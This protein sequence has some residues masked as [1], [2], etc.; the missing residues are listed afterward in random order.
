MRNEIDDIEKTLISDTLETAA[1]HGLHLTKELSFNEMGLDFRVA[2]AMEQNG[3]RW[4]L[5]IP[6]R[7]DIFSQIERE[8]KILEFVKSRV[9]VQ[10]PDWQI[11][12]PELVA[13]PMLTDPTA[14]TFDTQTYSVT[15]NINKDSE[16]YIESLALALANLHSSNVGEAVAA[17]ITNNT[18][19]CSRKSLL[20][21]IERVK[22]QI[23]MGH[24]L[25]AQW[26]SWISNDSIWP[27]FSVLTHGDLYA[28]H[29]T[30]DASSRVTGIID[31]SEAQ[32][33]D[34]AIDFAGHLAVFGVES[35]HALISAYARA[36]GKTWPSMI[37][38][39]SARHGASPLRYAVFAL[40]SNNADH[41]AS[42]KMQ[43]GIA[44]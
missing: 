37:E 32:V 9:G 12:T 1:R 40:D 23:G 25:E 33:A 18:S 21:D 19:E 26:K 11:C 13:Y 15:W 8:S 5:R 4:V 7:A 20:A 31:W 27:D 41:I 24:E 2:F 38:Q 3:K 39:I 6:R 28:G 14:I 16:V 34:P 10:V 35:L 30:A 36:G 43:L 29:I 44:V 42:A 17:G 22:N